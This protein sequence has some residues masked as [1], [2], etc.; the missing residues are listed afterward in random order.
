MVRHF[1][2]HFTYL[3]L[4]LALFAGGLGLPIPEEVPIVAGGVLAQQEVVRW[5]IALPVCLAGVLA[6]DTA[7]YWIGRHWGEKIL[8]WRPVRRV[9]SHA[10]E[11][12]LRARYRKHGVKIV[13][14]AR[15]VMGLRAAAFLTAGIAG[16]PFWR[17]LAVD[18]VAAVIGVPIGFGLAFLFTDHL[19]RTLEDVRRVERWLALYAMVGLAA[20]LAWLAWR[21]NRRL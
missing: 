2:E 14:L 5:W 13:F 7:L 18:S 11:E 1:I 10:R 3:G 20:W 16:V 12:A 4:F 6:G 9:L 15:H 17:F 19:E 21:Q 8:D